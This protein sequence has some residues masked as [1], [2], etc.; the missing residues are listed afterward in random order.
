VLGT[1]CSESSL[2]EFKVFSQGCAEQAEHLV[3]SWHKVPNPAWIGDIRE[4]LKSSGNFNEAAVDS[5][6]IS[7]V[8]EPKIYAYCFPAQRRIEVSATAYNHLRTVNL[9]LWMMTENIYREGQ[10]DDG[11]TVEENF[12]RMTSETSG[13]A[14]DFID[15]VLPSLFSLYFNNV[16][17]SS[18][19]IFRA[20]DI[21]T[22]MRAK[23]NAHSQVQFLMMHEYAHLLLHEGKSPSAELEREADIFSYETL[24]GAEDLWKD[25]TGIFFAS[26][27]WL[28][29][30]LALDR[31]IGAVLSGYEIDWIDVPI[32][33]RELAIYPLLRD[34]IQFSSEDERD[35]QFL[36]DALLFQA[37]ARL[38]ER[39]VEWIRSAARQF[40]KTH[41]FTS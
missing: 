28:F 16:D 10:V 38:R 11:L 20:P 21:D 40:E 13:Y 36:G 30:Y 34:R 24:I 18:L 31:I 4:A 41:C 2:S 19:P 39:G 22:F 3:G 33:D 15:K 27:R 35:C 17:Y 9:L 37:K 5:I 14:D 1:D 12:K 8:L 29:L 26:F 7:F 32:R 25:Y 23:L 6:D